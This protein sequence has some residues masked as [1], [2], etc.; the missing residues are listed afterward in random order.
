MADKNRLLLL[1]LLLM[2]VWETVF[3]EVGEDT[4]TPLSSLY[5]SSENISLY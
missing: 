3:A 5:R 4:P 1:L 2:L